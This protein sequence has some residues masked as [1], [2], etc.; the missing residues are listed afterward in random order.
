M[1][2]IHIKKALCVLLAALMACS[3]MAAGVVAEGPY[4][5]YNYDAWGTAV[6]SQNGYIVSDTITG[7]DMGLD[8]LSDP[9]SPLFISEDEPAELSDAKDF[10]LSPNNEFFIVDTG[11]NRIL[12]TDVNFNLIACYKTFTGS[13]LTEEYTASDGSTATREVTDLKSPYG[14]FVDEDDIMYIADR[15]KP[16]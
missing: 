16:K 3:V 10:F 5:S 1:T 8:Q 6:P 12:R 15:D 9:E 2:S 7:A 14:I 4:T 11:N 13:S